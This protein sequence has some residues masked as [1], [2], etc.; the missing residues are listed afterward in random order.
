MRKTLAQKAY[1][2]LQNG[3][4]AG[5]LP[6]GAMLSEAAIA[7]DLG[8]SRT[9]VGEAIRQL[10]D[11]GL[12][13][14][15]PRY[16][17]IVRRIERR[18]LAELY[19]M[20]EALES[21]SAARAAERISQHQIEDLDRY[22]AALDQ[23]GRQARENGLTELDE[24]LLNKF[25]AADMA[26]H[27]LIIQ[28]TG[29]SRIMKVVRSTRTIARIF[30]TRREP[31]NLAV[32]EGAFRYHTLILEALRRGDAE[33]ARRIT[34]EHISVSKQRALDQFDQVAYQEEGRPGLELN[35]PPDLEKELES[36]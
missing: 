12:V 18:E 2:H 5:R 34:E 19:E 30:H 4:V 21:Y 9:P 36:L 28:A 3:I 24:S 17:T 32:V 27:L 14:Q 7:K 20:R 22:C 13:E 15:V 16:G 23:I 8:I 29:N 33:E 6:S 11:E 26:F 1:E 31:H 25:L 35:L 10:A